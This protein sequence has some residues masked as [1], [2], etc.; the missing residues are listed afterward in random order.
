MTILRILA[1]IL[2]AALVLA[3]VS[4]TRELLLPGPAEDG[5]ERVPVSLRLEAAAVE[6]GSSATKAIQDPD[7]GVSSDGQIQNFLLLQ[8]DGQESDAPLVG[9]QL[10]VDHYPL[11]AEETVTLVA[12]SG[13]TLVALANTFGNIG[14]PNSITLGEFLENGFTTISGL[15]GLR[16]EYG[17][18]EYFRMSGSVCLATITSGSFVDLTLR[19]NCAK[20][21][22]NDTNN[23]HTN[24]ATGD[25]VVT[26]SQVRLESVNAKHYYWTHVA[27]GL[28]PLAFADSYATLTPYRFDDAMQPFTANDGSVTSYTFYVPANLRGSNGSGYQY[29]KGRG[30]PEGA[31]CF[32]LYGTYGAD[33]TPIVYTYY[34]GGDLTGDFNIRPNYKYTCNITLDAKGNAHSDFRIEDLAEQRFAVD[35]N[36]YMLHP[37]KVGGQSRVYSFPVRR[38]AVFWNPEGVNGGVYGASLKEGYESCAV[39][40]STEWTAEVLWS[41]F[42]MSAYLNGD[43]SDGCPEFFVKNAG[44]GY[45]DVI[46]VRIPAGMKGNVSV[47]MK[48]GGTILW[49]WHLW[50][51]DYDPDQYVVPEDGK[52]IYP[53]TGGEVHRYNGAIWHQAATETKSGLAKGFSMDRNLGAVV[54]RYADK[55][56][57]S[58][59]LWYA[60]GRKDPFLDRNQN[61]TQN[62]FYLNGTTSAVV[63]NNLS[64]YERVSWYDS[65]PDDKRVRYAVQHPTVFFVGLWNNHPNWASSEDDLSDGANNS[66]LWN[67]RRYWKHTGD[68]AILELKKSIYDPCPPGWKIPPSLAIWGD[69]TRAD[70]NTVKTG[71]YTTVFADNGQYY[72]PEGYVNREATGSIYYPAAGSRDYWL[73]IDNVG[74]GGQYYN[75]TPNGDQSSYLLSFD[76]SSVTINRLFYKYNALSVRCVRE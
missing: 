57:G 42:N 41:D 54:T 38:A 18:D 8:F 29:D 64:P 12:G 73:N 10:Y 50:I 52:Y 28:A 65:V 40:G 31:T 19:R 59:G 7:D 13:Q 9:G 15:D 30:A 2:P 27:D 67:D 24:G 66:Y 69:F 55:A 1:R 75:A 60:F 16:T 56:Q 63:V 32:R 48:V 53:V 58:L 14:I 49:S 3:S 6:A 33:D 76:G 20:I 70:E 68:Q 25:D 39:D 72:Y 44:T 74:T 45:E 71:T 36:S 22:V 23:T 21:V 47:A 61:G 17:G 26:L 43:D 11:L 37:P 46:K 5:L 34:L 4:C 35:A 51:T 62:W